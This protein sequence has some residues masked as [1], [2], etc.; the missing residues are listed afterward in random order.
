[1]SGHAK[2]IGAPLVGRDEKNIG[3]DGNA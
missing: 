2:A 1:V 3:H